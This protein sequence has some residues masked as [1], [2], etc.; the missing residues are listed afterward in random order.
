MPTA[1]SLTPSEFIDKGNEIFDM[2][3]GFGD[4]MPQVVAELRSI[5][6]STANIA[7]IVAKHVTGGRS[8][9]PKSN[10]EV[11]TITDAVATQG[12]SS[13]RDKENKVLE[14]IQRSGG[15]PNT[16]VS[17]SEAGHKAAPVG[18]GRTFNLAALRE[19]VTFL[20]QNPQFITLI[21]SMFSAKLPT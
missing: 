6:T 12:F 11:L 2:L 21:W 14:A 4:D 13:L 3:L 7:A 16:S 15:D 1:R 5:Q 20:M 17:A 8:A 19:I 9:S 10:V 18:P